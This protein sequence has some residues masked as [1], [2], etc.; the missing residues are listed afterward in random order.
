MTD[1]TEI[2]KNNDKKTTNKW[3]NKY[4]DFS[5]LWLA[6]ILLTLS[7]I[8]IRYPCS[9]CWITNNSKKMSTK[10]CRK[11]HFYLL[12]RRFYFFGIFWGQPGILINT[13]KKRMFFAVSTWKS[14]RRWTGSLWAN[15]T[16]CSIFGTAGMPSTGWMWPWFMIGC[17]WKAWTLDMQ[18]DSTTATECFFHMERGAVL[19]E[20]WMTV[21]IIRWIT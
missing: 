16:I 10:N 18:C 19:H 1:K 2:T 20:W 4:V 21:W 6:K 11:G 9:L 8:D 5:N 15:S 13:N 7:N 12:L 3:Q 17:A 14:W